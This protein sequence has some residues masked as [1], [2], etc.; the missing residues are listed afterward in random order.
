MSDVKEAAN[1]LYI[2]AISKKLN[3]PKIWEETKCIQTCAATL[4]VHRIPDGF[5]T[6]EAFNDLVEKYGLVEEKI[7]ATVEEKKKRK[8]S[9]AAEAVI[10]AVADED[11]DDDNK[12]KK[13]KKI[14]SVAEEENRV[15]ADAIREMSTI[16]FKNKDARKG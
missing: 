14:E 12:P 4:L 16:Y 10:A 2:H 11:G 13:A 9:S 5:D 3:F 15:I 7:T 6:E 8:A 1:K